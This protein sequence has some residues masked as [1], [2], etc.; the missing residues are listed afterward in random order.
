[1]S[2]QTIVRTTDALTKQIAPKNTGFSTKPSK[3][4]TNENN[5]S[6]AAKHLFLMENK[7]KRIG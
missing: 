6:E 3:G 2:S 7:V 5:Y 1:M 4:T